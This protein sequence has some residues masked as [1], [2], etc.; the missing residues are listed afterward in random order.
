MEILFEDEHLMVVNK[1]SGIPSN[2]LADSNVDLPS[3]E[4]QLSRLCAPSPIYLLHRLDVGTSGVLLFARSPEAFQQ[5]RDLFRLKQIKKLYWAWSEAKYEGALPFEMK[6]EI[7]HH[8]KSK[9]RMVVVEPEKMAKRP[10]TFYRGNPLPAHTKILGMEE[11]SFMGRKLFRYDVEIVTGVMHQIRVHLKHVG[12]PLIG[13]PIYGTK[14]EL[15]PTNDSGNTSNSPLPRLGLH[16]H[17]IEFRLNH[18]EY[19]IEAP[20]SGNP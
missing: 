14:S 19:K 16:A 5:M 1:P 9:K 13:D 3:M 4:E 2:T 12:L 17:R 15:N 10:Q 6:N 11:C 8:P 7:A 20:I 18:F